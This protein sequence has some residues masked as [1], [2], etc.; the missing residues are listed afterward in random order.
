[1]DSGSTTTTTSSSSSPSFISSLISS[2]SFSSPFKDGVM[3][4]MLY[5]SKEELQRFKQLLVDENPRPG[6]VQLTWDQVRT[7]T[8]GEVI[9]LL[10]EFFPGRLAWDVT[11]DIFAK[12]N[13][14]QLCL[15]VQMELQDILPNLEPEALNPRGTQMNVE[16]EESDE[17][18]N[19]RLRLTCQYRP[20]GNKRTWPGNQ[21]DFFYQDIPAHQRL[22]PCLFL[23]RRPQGRPPKTVVL[24]G[25]AGVGKTSLAYKVM[26]EWA[27]NTFY[28]HKFRYAFYVP[29]GDVAW[30]TEQ[31]LCELLSRQWPGSRAL[32]SKV[33]S[34]PEQLLLVLDGFEELTWTPTDPPEDLSEDWSQKLPGSVLLASLLSRKM[35]PEATLLLLLRLSSWRVT[36]PFLKSPSVITLMGFTEV[37]KARYFRTYFGNKEQAERALRFVM[38]NPILFPMCQVPAV[39]WLV[40]SRLKEQMERGANLAV[41]FP[42]ATA[43]FAR[44]LSS[45]LPGPAGS[46]LCGPRQEQLA[47]V[48]NLA[49]EG[50]WNRRWVFGKKDL[51]QAKLDAPAVAA[52]LGANILR[53]VV[54]GEDRYAFALLSFQEFFAALLYVLCFPQSLPD[55]QALDQAHVKRLVAY[56][57][58]KRNHLAHMAVF[59]FGL[60]NESCARAVER[61][62]GCQLSLGNKKEVPKVA[63]LW[64]EC[65]PPTVHHGVPHLFHCLYEIQEPT[66]LSQILHDCQKATLIIRKN[67]DLQVSA[68]CLRHCQCLREVELTVTLTIAKADSR[69]PCAPSS[70][71]PEGN[72]L[73]FHW[74]QDLCS[75]FRTHESLEALALTNSLMEPDTVRVLSAALKHP[76]C[77]LRKL[78]LRHM[79]RSLMIEDLILV[80][81]ENQYL[82]H[83]EIQ[84]TAVQ[85]E[86]VEALGMALKYQQCFLQCLRLE[87]C[88]VTPKSLRSLAR[89]L[90][91]NFHLKTLMLSNSSL[92]DSGA[93]YLSVT[94]LERLSL[95]N[96]DHT[97]LR[98]NSLI[99]PLEN[100][101][102]LTHLSLAG[103]ALNEEGAIE[104]WD[105]LQ[106]AKCPLQRLVLRSCALT[107]GCCQ[108]MASALSQNKTLRSL[109][110]GLNSLKDEGVTLLCGA[111]LDGGAGLQVLELEGCL[112]T[113]G[114]CQAVNSMLLRHHSLRYLDVSRNDIG[115]GGVQLLR[116]TFRKW[117]CDTK[118]VLERKQSCGVDLMA[119]L[120]GPAVDEAVL[121]VVQDWD[122]EGSAGAAQTD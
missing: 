14:M 93:Y 29:C 12:M 15:R 121:K 54:G 3:L 24:Q 97:L 21:A 40:C 115:R 32:M 35:L 45:V 4:Y 67:K 56:P 83:L 122:A 81:M 110:L 71:G 117:T 5:L 70:A 111:L 26:S 87:D 73:R 22:L 72:N 18:Q 95:E 108:D 65:G 1:M 104:L 113:S 47:G 98:Y 25:V 60:L 94:H 118:I 36:K 112:L 100:S 2:S 55:F 96:C 11:H 120:E 8:W 28:R 44:Y 88:S 27:G 101:Q 41:A 84:G 85:G 86:A 64:R 16:A 105:A 10:T 89:N 119:R 48:C 34:Q 109:D 74:W 30:D 13:Q 79:H 58:S 9:H 103:N 69:H 61:S 49:A 82:N 52:L 19:Y 37:E 63:A 17:I 91:S 38:G 76:H 77:K 68:F 114:C 46:P 107:P 51:E 90:R 66:F 31:S 62:F 7:A 50:M 102:R 116:E 80:L 99:C 53:R 59:L 106:H 42:N 33:M 75:V 23:P 6:S 43:V 78:I 20:E 39:C 92:E 57:G